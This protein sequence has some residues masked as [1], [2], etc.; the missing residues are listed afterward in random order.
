MNTYALHAANLSELDAAILN[1]KNNHFKPTLGIVFSSI[2]K[3]LSKISKVFDEQDIDLFGCTTAGEILNDQ[4]YD[5][6]IVG[7]LFDMNPANYKL[8]ASIDAEKATFEQARITGEFAI[9]TFENPAIIIAS[10][11]VAINAQD[12]VDGLKAGL[13]KEVP[14]FGG[15][16]A[17]DLDLKQTCVFCRKGISDKGLLSLVFDNDKISIDGMAISG[18]EAIGDFHTVTKSE[19]NIIYTI[20]DEP[21]LDV[22]IKYFGYLIILT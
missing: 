20:D 17:D 11:G 15:L 6:S 19:G 1:C 21:A 4:I 2:D 22:F 13:G 16:A 8:Y 3:D 14:I 9:Q 12:I 10:G 7:L 5:T 18:W